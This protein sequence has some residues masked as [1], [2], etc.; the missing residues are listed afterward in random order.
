MYLPKTPIRFI[1]YFLKNQYGKVLLMMLASLAWASKESLFP[2]FLKNFVNTLQ[3]YP[4]DPEKA[5]N[6][7]GSLFSFFYLVGVH[8]DLLP[9][10]PGRFSDFEERPP[11]AREEVVL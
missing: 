1:F 3:S 9:F 4:G 7:V 11:N 2:Y 8:R 6:A 10:P 5:L